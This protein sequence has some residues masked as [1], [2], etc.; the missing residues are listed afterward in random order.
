MAYY[1]TDSGQAAVLRSGLHG[2]QNTPPSSLTRFR[3]ERLVSPAIAPIDAQ[4]HTT[5]VR[6]TEQ[7]A[8][9][10]ELAAALRSEYHG[11][12]DSPPTSLP[13][14]R[15]E[16]P[17]SSA[18]APIDVQVHTTSVRATEQPA[19]RIEL[20][21]TTLP[22]PTEPAAPVTPPAPRASSISSLSTAP[23]NTKSLSPQPHRLK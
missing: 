3:D 6:A 14:I 10:I 19:R 12:Q 4:I 17:A 23:N 18:F 9:T 13:V 21:P 22:A 1:I 8:R 11:A 2:A 16:R 15:D 7:A 5:P 20:P